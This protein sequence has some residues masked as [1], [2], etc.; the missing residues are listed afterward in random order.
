[1]ERSCGLKYGRKWPRVARNEGC[2]NIGL[3]FTAPLQAASRQKMSSMCQEELL[4][5]QELSVLP[6]LINVL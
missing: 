1:M 4:L 5:T 2:I 6:F 3:E